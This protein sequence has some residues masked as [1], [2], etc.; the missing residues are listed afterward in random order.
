MKWKNSGPNLKPYG[1]IKIWTK[2]N[3]QA[4]IKPNIVTMVC[5]C[6]FLF[7]AWPKKLI[8]LAKKK[9]ST[10]AGVTGL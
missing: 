1:E 6:Y 2:V 8:L 9:I 4:I 7:S 10:K 5:N 3:T